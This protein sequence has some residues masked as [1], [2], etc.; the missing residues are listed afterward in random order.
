M[1]E[2]I[3]VQRFV[4]ELLRSF[5]DLGEIAHHALIVQRLSNNRDGRLHAVPM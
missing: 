1:N 3:V 5:G 2:E 4:D